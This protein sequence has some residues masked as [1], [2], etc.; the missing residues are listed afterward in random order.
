LGDAGLD[1]IVDEKQWDDKEDQLDDGNEEKFEEGGTEEG[2]TLAGESHT[3]T[4]ED[5]GGKEKE[6]PEDGGKE[7][8]EGEMGAENEKEVNAAADEDTTIEKQH[9]D[10]RDETKAAEEEVTK[11]GEDGQ[12][13]P[14]EEGVGGMGNDDDDKGLEGDEALLPENMAIEEEDGNNDDVGGSEDGMSLGFE[15]QVSSTV[16]TT[17]YS[18]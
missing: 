3:K 7:K 13:E 1:N 16:T 8:E 2:E 12:E 11:A 9:V 15:P 17:V 5:E 10:K 4:E 18:V 14:D 6:K